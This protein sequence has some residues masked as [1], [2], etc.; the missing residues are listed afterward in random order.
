MSVP[1]AYLGIVLIWTTTPLAIKWSG[2]DVG[3]L[4]GVSMRMFIALI[5]S[6]ALVMI[7]RKAFPWDRKSIQVY[8]AIGIPLFLAMSFVYWGAQ[9]IPSGLISVLFGLTPLFTGLLA[10]FWLSEKSFTLP[11][12]VGMLLGFVGLIVI[13]YQGFALGPAMLV[14]MISVL[15]A[16]FFHSF[17]TV[18]VKQ[19]ASELPVYVANTGGLV[20]A[21]SLY[22]M[23]WFILG[24]EIPVSV[25]A[26]A[27]YSIT[28]LAI[29]GSV[30]GAMLFYYALKHVSATSI[31]LLPLITP[32]SCLLLGQWLNGEIISTST[33]YGTA[34]ILSGLLVYQWSALMKGT[35]KRFVINPGQILESQQNEK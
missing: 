20:V 18:W 30:F 25:P 9:Y 10:T 24:E 14:G 34:I 33:M 19:V 26:H 35:V 28:Y 23:S 4:F 2:E 13:F 8:L 32:V 11:K 6:L 22:V 29:F 31:G 21:S 16:V 27:A 15:A 7:L 17:G 5:F 12:T 3:F 1:L